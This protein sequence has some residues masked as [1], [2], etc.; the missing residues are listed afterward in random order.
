MVAAGMAL[1]SGGARGV[2]RLAM[3]VAQQAGGSVIGVLADSLKSRIGGNEVRT[4][5]DEVTT[6]LITQQ[7]PSAGFSVA[8]AMGRNKLI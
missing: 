4:S 7:D 8:A 3:D 6:C 1:V 2:D 5:L